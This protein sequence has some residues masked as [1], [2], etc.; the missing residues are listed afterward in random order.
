MTVDV[1]GAAR[2]R[3]ASAYLSQSNAFVGVYEPRLG[4][5]PPAVD[6]S[7][8]KYEL[9]ESRDLLRNDAEGIEPR[10][11]ILNTLKE[12]ASEKLEERG[13]LTSPRGPTTATSRRRG[14]PSGKR[15]SPRHG[16]KAAR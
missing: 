14:M 1:E 3:V 15:P 4:D 5:G 7:L 9:G 10:L 16:R 6:R 11:A 12:Y 13:G 2:R 8:Q